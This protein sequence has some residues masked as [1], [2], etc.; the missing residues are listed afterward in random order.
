MA[1][2]VV[3]EVVVEDIA[4]TMARYWWVFLLRGLLAI[5]FGVIA[6]TYPGITL[7]V[8]VIF[9]GAYALVDGAFIIGATLANWRH[10]ENHWLPMLQGILGVFVGVLTFRLPA[11]TALGLLIYIAA[12]SLATGALEIVAAIELRKVMKGELW[13]L[14]S[15][16]C[17]VI[18]AFLLMLNPFA[19]AIGLLWLIAVWAVVFGVLLIGLSFKLLRHSGALH[20]SQ[21][22]SFAT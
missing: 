20:Q 13:L 3:E 10:M 8:L 12:W 11:V 16:I 18:F 15:G 1:E 21:K 19:A 22:P 5:A 2:L 7:A 4:S 9:F 6:F 17:S 14:L